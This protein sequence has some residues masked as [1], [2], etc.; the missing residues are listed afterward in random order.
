M[1]LDLLETIRRIR[2]H[3]ELQDCVV[4]NA[5]AGVTFTSSLGKFVVPRV[6]FSQAVLEIEDLE[7]NVS[8]KDDD[9]Y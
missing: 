1:R 7:A 6:F 4:E 2:D 3:V 8:G 5:V 9:E